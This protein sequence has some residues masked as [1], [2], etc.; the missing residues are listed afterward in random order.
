MRILIITTGRQ[1][2]SILRN[3]ATELLKSP[4]MDAS[5][6]AGGMACDD[7][8]GNIAA[9]IAEEGFPLAD[10]CEWDTSES[11]CHQIAAILPKAER[12]L[13]NLAPDM[14]ML[15]GDRFETLAFAQTALFLKI[16][17]VHL[18]GGEE[19]LGAIDNRIRHA[20]TQMSSLHFVSCERHRD[21]V[22][23]MGAEENAVF[24]VGAP[25][26]DSLRAAGLPSIE[27]VLEKLE[28]PSRTS[29]HPLFLVTYHPPT[30]LG[31][32]D[33]E[34]ASLLE[35]L[36]TFDARIIFTVPN[37][38]PGSVPILQRIRDFVQTAPD[39]RV[40]VKALGP[41]RY[42]TVLKN[43]DAVIGNSSSGIIE[44]PAVPVPT[45]NIGL[46]Q[47]GRDMAPSVI[48]IPSPTTTT[49]E[50]AIQQALTPEFKKSLSAADSI[51][52]DGTASTQIKTILERFRDEQP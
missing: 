29:S 31:D 40:V 50:Q 43:C 21:R 34:M 30:L 13:A 20:I 22:I 10:K 5:I 42:W 11:I 17:I 38:D 12:Q 4:S 9:K 37:N 18:H 51:F 27:K 26:L 1:D 8:Y 32:A 36:D 24:N 28:F 49:I 44:A 19:T 25:G 16:P 46:R 6:L 7:E 15:L 41:K 14:L 33:T 39:K 52:G 23:A 47:A 48:D 3:V 35:A 45:I 2:W